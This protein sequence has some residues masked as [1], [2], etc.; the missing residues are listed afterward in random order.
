MMKTIGIIGGMGPKATDY[1]YRLIIDH[2]RASKDQEHLDLIII[3]RASTP[4][5]T[6]Y[7]LD[8]TK[9]SPIPSLIRD[10]KILELSEVQAF[11][12]ACNT[13]HSFADYF[14]SATNLPFINMIEETV[15]NLSQKNRKRA[16]ILATTGTIIS[17][18][19]QK[20]LLGFG[21]DYYEPSPEIQNKV[22]KIIYDEVKA[23]NSIDRESFLE[24]EEELRKNG[25]DC[26]VLGCTELS[27]VTALPFFHADFFSDSSES[28]ARAIV[29]E[30][31]GEWI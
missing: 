23:G 24:I 30:S 12:M 1:L 5:R 10:I 22:M 21:L 15:R 28:L 26:A 31:G 27:T 9:E 4:D 2:T 29:R 13:S 6:E 7:I 20:E 18:V 25:C 17:G 3:N 11:C 14:L 16:G 19:Y 8:P